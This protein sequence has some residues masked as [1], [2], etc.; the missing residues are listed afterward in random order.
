VQ[1][2]TIAQIQPITVHPR[3]Q[4][5]K[6]MPPN[7]RLPRPTIEGRKYITPQKIMKSIPT[8]LS[9]AVSVEAKPDRAGF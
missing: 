5:T 1:A 4:F 9:R 2:Q 6:K 3:K 8:L 7:D